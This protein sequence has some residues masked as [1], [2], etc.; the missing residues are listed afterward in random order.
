MVSY[1]GNKVH[2]NALFGG[3]AKTQVDGQPKSKSGAY[4]IFAANLNSLYNARHRGSSQEF[5]MKLTGRQ[6][7]LRFTRYKKL[8]VKA[9]NL[10]GGTGAGVTDEDVAAG[11]TTVEVKLETICP[12]YAEMDILFGGKP[13]VTPFALFDSGDF[14]DSGDA[15]EVVDDIEAEDMSEK[16]IASD[17]GKLVLA[18]CDCVCALT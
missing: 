7:Q 11:I 6:L 12:C 15:E 10:L 1:L 3:G 9:K 4:D 8:Y 18:G 5:K 16:E 17:E 2:F 13:N 14:L